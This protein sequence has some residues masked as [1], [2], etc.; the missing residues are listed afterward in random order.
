MPLIVRITL[1]RKMEICGHQRYLRPT[2]ILMGVRKVH[3][4]SAAC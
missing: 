2:F 3:C 4:W 1:M